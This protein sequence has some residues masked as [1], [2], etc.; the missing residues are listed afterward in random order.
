[1]YEVYFFKK[2]IN[3]EN[4][5]WKNNFLFL[6]LSDHMK[7]RYEQMKS[8]EWYQFNVEDMDYEHEDFIFNEFIFDTN[9]MDKYK[10]AHSL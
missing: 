8:M 6:A 4:F 7:F 1:M 9:F 5:L 10:V 3:L 2:N